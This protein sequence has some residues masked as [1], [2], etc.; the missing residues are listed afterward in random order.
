M[1]TATFYPNAYPTDRVTH[2][3]DATMEL[4][5][6]GVEVH[7]TQMCL[8]NEAKDYDEIRIEYPHRTIL[9]TNNHDG[10]Y[11]CRQTDRQVRWANN[12]LKMWENGIF[13]D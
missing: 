2:S 12:F 11:E 4:L 6:H 1:S 13:D 8:L 10:T 9:L 7:T 3:Y 5:A